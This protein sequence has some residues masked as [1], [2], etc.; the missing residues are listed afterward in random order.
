MH[1]YPVSLKVQVSPVE[2]NVVYDLSDIGAV[3][4]GQVF[5]ACETGNI[6]VISIKMDASNTYVGDI[7]LWLGAEPGDGNTL[8]G[9][10]PTICCYRYQYDWSCYY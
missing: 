8:R 1:S 5:T 2:Q 10:L 4:D 7:D 9:C 6:D 3:P